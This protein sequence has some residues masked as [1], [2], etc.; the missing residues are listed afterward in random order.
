MI[1][2][3][4]PTEH[5]A[6]LRLE[7]ASYWHAGSGRGS[8]YHLDALCERDTDALPILPG[9]QLKGLLRN[10]LRRA[11]AWGWLAALALPEG[12]LANHETLLFGSASQQ[13]GRGAT[14]PGVL[15]VDSARLPAGERHWLAADTQAD[16]RVEL[17]GELF[18][19]A[20]NEQGSAQ[21]YSLRGTEV[22][23]PMTLEAPLALE[24]SSQHTALR[25][26]QKRYL[27]SG[28]GWQAL[29][30]ALPLVDAVGAHRSRGLGEARLEL[31]LPRQG[32]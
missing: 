32:A 14:E 10:A 26:Q 13:L 20:I 25:V 1:Q 18:S 3:P 17:F 29:T 19:T 28:A 15:R 9:R 5:Q 24:L 11:E 22:C 2:S 16:L 21:R 27:E 12:P 4:A 8:G 31:I 23:I 30:A 6:Q 7:L